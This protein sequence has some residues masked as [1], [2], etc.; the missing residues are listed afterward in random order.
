MYLLDAQSQATH[1]LKCSPTNMKDT[2]S[3]ARIFM[4]VGKDVF[5]KVLHHSLL[6]TRGSEKAMQ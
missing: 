5:K 2:Y 3:M 4:L 1:T 6:E